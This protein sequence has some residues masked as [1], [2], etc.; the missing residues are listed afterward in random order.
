[1]KLTESQVDELIMLIHLEFLSLGASPKHI[2]NKGNQSKLRYD[3]TYHTSH[4][5]DYVNMSERF[6]DINMSEWRL[7][8]A[9]S[10]L[11]RNYIVGAAK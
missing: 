9:M 1:M 10:K 11:T 5:F 3:V 6:F 4:W 2:V 8:Q 7:E